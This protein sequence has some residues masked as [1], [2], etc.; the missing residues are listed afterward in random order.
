MKMF[1]FQQALREHQVASEVSASAQ[2]AMIGAVCTLEVC[3]LS[4]MHTS[5]PLI[6]Y[7]CLA[8]C[9]VGMFQNTL[10]VKSH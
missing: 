2:K 3:A 10:L 7:S 6:Y 9:V 8:V 5:L 4:Q 1:Q